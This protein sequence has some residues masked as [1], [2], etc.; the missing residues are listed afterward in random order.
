VRLVALVMA[1]RDLGLLRLHLTSPPSEQAAGAP[2]VERSVVVR[3]DPVRRQRP[4]HHHHD[5]LPRS[6][7]RE[8]GSVAA[9]AD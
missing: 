4:L 5:P 3:E 7:S 8:L 1:L 2:V 9:F 6:C